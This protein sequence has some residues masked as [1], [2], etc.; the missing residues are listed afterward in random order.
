M[1]EGMAWGL[2]EGFAISNSDDGTAPQN[3]TAWL[4]DPERIDDWAWRSVHLTAVASKRIVHAYYGRNASKSYFDG[5][6]KGGQEALMEAQRFPKDFDGIAAGNPGNYWTHL[7]ASFLWN[8]LAMTATPASNLPN[9]SLALLHAHV[10]EA[11]GRGAAVARGFLFNPGSCH[12]DPAPLTCKSNAQ[13]DCLTA[14]QVAAAQKIYDGPVNPRTG[15]RI[16]PGMPRGGELEWKAYRGGLVHFFVQPFFGSTLLQPAGWRAKSF[17]FD[18][19]LMQ[20]DT[21]LGPTVNATNTDLAPFFA[22]GGKLLL[23]Q[24]WG[25][26]LN[27]AYYLIEYYRS[28]LA[29]VPRRYKDSVRLF[30]VPGANH[31]GEGP[32]GKSDWLAALDAWVTSGRPPQRIVSIPQKKDGLSAAYQLCPYGMASTYRDCANQ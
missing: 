5:S 17:D 10:L 30:M 13:T 14:E 15:E 26:Q 22:R 4:N 29:T 23:H 32:V 12:Y 25:D 6:S 31:A 8:T 19:D 20:A 21:V 1:V 28:V 7:M 27:S 24:S 11:C 2:E 9:A 3:S 16:F 18:H